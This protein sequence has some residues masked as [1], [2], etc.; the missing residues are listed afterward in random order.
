MEN[1]GSHKRNP[2]C[3]LGPLCREHFPGL[4]EYAAVTGPT[5]S[6]DHYVVALDIV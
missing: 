3:I 5:F 2:N 6:F 1:A 4:V